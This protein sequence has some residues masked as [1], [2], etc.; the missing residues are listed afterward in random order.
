MRFGSGDQFN[1]R[2]GHMLKE[3]VNQCI[4][5]SAV[6]EDSLLTGQCCTFGGLQSALCGC[7]ILR[8]KWNEK[9]ACLHDLQGESALGIQHAQQEL[10]CGVIC[11]GR[12]ASGYALAR[13]EGVT[14]PMKRAATD[15]WAF[16]GQA[17]SRAGD[18]EGGLLDTGSDGG[19]RTP[20][21]RV[22]LPTRSEQRRKGTSF[23]PCC[24]SGLAHSTGNRW[25]G[26]GDWLVG[27][28]IWLSATCN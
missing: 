5:F 12:Q 13:Y 3:R 23:L 4:D 8:A 19:R 16:D 1:R 17:P 14:L 18:A 9:R 7:G 10:G 24:G 28:I 27:V 6:T 15:G 20:A 21:L 11:S 22:S 26:N 2:M 25:I